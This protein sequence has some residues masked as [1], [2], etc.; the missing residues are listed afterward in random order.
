[1]YLFLLFVADEAADKRFL[2]FSWDLSNLRFLVP[3]AF[4]G[5]FTIFFPSDQG[6]L[7]FF[8]QSEVL[9]FDFLPHLHPPS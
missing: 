6:W 9:L 4:F 5:D 7:L 1:M 3:F 2:F 8:V